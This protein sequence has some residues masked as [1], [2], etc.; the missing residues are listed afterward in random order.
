[1]KRF[2]RTDESVEEEGEGLKPERQKF[3]E[4]YKN[5][6]TCVKTESGFVNA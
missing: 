6:K 2:Q 4:N 5:L 3:Y 1:M